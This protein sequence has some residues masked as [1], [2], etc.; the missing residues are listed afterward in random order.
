MCEFNLYLKFAGTGKI[1]GPVGDMHAIKLT[2]NTVSLVW[3]PPTDNITITNYV[4]HYQKVN[5]VTVHENTIKL[6][7]VYYIVF[8]LKYSVLKNA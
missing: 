3:N 2:N 4:V 8:I 7:Q 6:D 5:N 1:P